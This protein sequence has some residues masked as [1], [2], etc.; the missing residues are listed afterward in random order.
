MY[1]STCACKCTKPTPMSL[2]PYLMSL[3]KNDCHIVNMT[4]RD[5]LLLEHMCV[6]IPPTA[7]SC[8]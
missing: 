4:H 6:K 7:T 2:Y 5:I 1:V 8:H 3:H